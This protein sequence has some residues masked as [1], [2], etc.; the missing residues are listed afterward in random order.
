MPL[1]KQRWNIY[2]EIKLYPQI[3]PDNSWPDEARLSATWYNL[4]ITREQQTY[5]TQTP[6]PLLQQ[7][8]HFFK[9]HTLLPGFVW[10]PHLLETRFVIGWEKKQ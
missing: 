3:L 6:R 4:F 10:N 8:W 5:F 2:E 9:P 1:K 7:S